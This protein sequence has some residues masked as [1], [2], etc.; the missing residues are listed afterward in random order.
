MISL[1]N[2]E[3]F[4]PIQEFVQTLGLKPGMKVLDIG[5]GTGGSA[6][7]MAQNYG[8]QVLGIDLSENMLA[9][10]NEHKETFEENVQNIV[11][12]RYLDATKA[13][14][15]ENYFDVIYSRDAIMHIADKEQLYA[16][17]LTWLKPGGKLLVSEYV[18]GRN[19]PNLDTEYV[20][21]LTDR[22]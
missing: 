1:I 2:D 20:D 12:F 18:H 22:G 13:A 4:S 5:C 8:A 21:Y 3:L 7:F 14:F 15:P 11:S 17:V 9:V 10:A 19:Y 6:F 16:K